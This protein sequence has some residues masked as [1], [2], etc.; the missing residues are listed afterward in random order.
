MFEG[1]RYHDIR[2]WKEAEDLLN[3]QPKAWN[4]SGKT[5]DDFYRVVDSST[6]RTTGLPFLRASLTRIRI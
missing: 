2:R 5:Q 6:K 1:R 4:V 3:R